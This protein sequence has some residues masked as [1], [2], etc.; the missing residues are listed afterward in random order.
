VD[1]LLVFVAVLMAYSNGAT[2]LDRF[3]EARRVTVAMHPTRRRPGKSYRGFAKALVARSA[4]LLGAVADHLRRRLERDARAASQWLTHGFAVFGVDSTK[5]DCPMT[6]ANEEAIGVASR[7]K[8]W[9]Q[10]VLTTL[11]HVGT[12]VPW[13][14]LRGDARGSERAHLLGLLATLPAGALILADAGF[15]GYEFFASILAA[16]RHVL[17]RVG[18]NVRLLSGGGVHTERRRRGDLLWLWPDAAQKANRPPL[19]LRLVTAVDPRR[20]RRVHLLTSVLDTGALDDEQV[21]GLYAMRWAVELKFRSLKQVM[22]RRK[23]LSDAPA[24]ARV[25]CD[26]SAV[27]HWMLE[28]MS[29]QRSGRRRRSVASALRAVRR[30]MAGVARRRLA[31]L[32]GAAVADDGYERVGPKHARHWPHQK[33][34]RAPG[35]PKARTATPEEVTRAATLTAIGV[36]A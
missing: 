10:V 4:A 30:S 13:A 18:A 8:S 36:A 34:A 19:T 31:A 29:W 3:H 21:I 7:R 15:V 1:R 35:E 26:W 6:R 25:E 32:L 28:M 24:T 12:N 11:F 17:V 20:N 22:G 2:L 5:L 23:L 9:P 16:E 14:F 27:G 33:R